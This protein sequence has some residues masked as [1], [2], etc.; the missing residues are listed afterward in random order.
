MKEGMLLLVDA[1][2]RATR[3]TAARVTRRGIIEEFGGCFSG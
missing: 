2:R 1:K 3:V